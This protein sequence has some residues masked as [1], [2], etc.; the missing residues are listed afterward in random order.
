[1]CKC[2]NVWRIK[3]WWGGFYRGESW[4]TE[5]SS[6]KNEKGKNWELLGGSW[7]FQ[8]RYGNVMEAS[9]KQ[10]KCPF[11]RWGMVSYECV[12]RIKMSCNT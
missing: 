9:F 10:L 12:K 6:G 5:E 8:Q 3:R 7:I 4:E 1:M 11:C 2:L